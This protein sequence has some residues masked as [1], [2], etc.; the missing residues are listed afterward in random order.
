M[1]RRTT[2]VPVPA[3][4]T[5]VELLVVIAI[6]GVLVALL[7]PAVQGARESAR[8]TQCMNNLKQIGVALHLFHSA[9]GRLPYAA[10]NCCGDLPDTRGDLWTTAILPELEFRPLYEQ[11]D[12]TKYARSWPTSVV[13]TVVPTYI[14]PS[15][16]QASSPVL[17][18]R[19][20]RDN[21]AVALGLWYPGS[22]GPTHPDYCDF[23]PDPSPSPKNWCCQGYNY[24]TLPGAGYEAGSHVG[25]FGRYKNAVHFEVVSD[26]LSNTILN[27][28]TLPGQCSFISAFSANFNISSTN[29]PINHF[30]SNIGNPQLIWWRACGF[31][32]M[33]PG[34]VSFLFADGAVHFLSESI[35]FQT[36]NALGT[37]AGR[38]IVTIPE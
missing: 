4:F 18:D 36:I 31:K 5:L 1:N 37:R 38:E 26:G 15:D 7:L 11:I 35:D 21:P 32:S 29:V 24:G 25:M 14:C 16:P 33:H 23:C 20:A 27:G 30:E 10:G 8:R 17:R 9:R 22:M 28:E 2:R 34:G 6:I 13:T 12:Q 19:F 3:G